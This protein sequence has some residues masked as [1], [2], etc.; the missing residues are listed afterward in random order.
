MFQRRFV[1]STLLVAALATLPG[2]P[3]E[4]FLRALTR[5]GAGAHA[6]AGV[7]ADAGRPEDAG[8][9]APPDVARP[10]AR[11]PYTPLG[12]VQFIDFFKPHHR[13]AIDM[14]Q[15]VIERGADP[16]VRRLAT[17]MRDAQT[18]EYEHMRDVREELTG[19]GHYPPIEDPAAE[20]DMTHMAAL[21]GAE[22]D[23]AFLVHM[24]PHHGSGLAPAHR[25]QPH[26]RRAD[27]REL[28]RAMYE[29]QSEEVGEMHAL[30]DRMTGDARAAIREESLRI[31]PSAVR[32]PTDPRAPFTP[33]DD[34]RFTDFFVPHHRDAV[35]MAEMVL[36]RGA[37]PE[38]RRMA[39]EVR[40]AQTEEIALMA[41][42]RRALGVDAEPPPIHDPH[43]ERD[44]D[45]MR[46]L[47]G[48]AL[49]RMFLEEMIPHHGSGLEPAHRAHPVLRRSDLS[50]LATDMM[51]AQSREIGEMRAVL[52]R[53]GGVH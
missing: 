29:H 8:L 16:E 3:W 32:M 17:E 13:M 43:M 49:D 15:M 4:E 11:A 30:L 27:L 33:T 34:V 10:D 44:M 20:A 31:D 50:A 2:C 22:L 26:L 35:M 51:D 53:L 5:G 28:A 42:A 7:V 6:D 9:S 21:S 37:D 19:E 36:A 12:D 39:A 52:D 48:V 1:R 40:D 38:V 23:R 24:I 41:A 18:R 25:A 46:S 45:M 47:S 14:A